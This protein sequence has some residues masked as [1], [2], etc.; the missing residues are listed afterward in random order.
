MLCVM[1]KDDTLVLS[2]HTEFGKQATLQAY[3][4]LG[5]LILIRA[6]RNVIK[7]LEAGST[8]ICNRFLSFCLLKY[9]IL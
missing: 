2:V 4:Q 7:G 8:G 9:M 6:F 3:L 1:A 5:E